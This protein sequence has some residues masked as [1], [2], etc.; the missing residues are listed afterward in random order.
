MLHVDLV[1]VTSIEKWSN[2]RSNLP[3]ASHGDYKKCHYKDCSQINL[4]SHYNQLTPT[5][6]LIH[7]QQVSYKLGSS[8]KFCIS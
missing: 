2:T 8:I 5:V 3:S 4:N 6:S 1:S 7:T